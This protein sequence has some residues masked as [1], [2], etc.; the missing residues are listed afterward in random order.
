[1]RLGRKET[2]AQICF[3]GR[4]GDQRRETDSGFYPLFHF[5]NQ[6]ENIT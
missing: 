1:M 4:E 6:W 5:V 3:S 2:G